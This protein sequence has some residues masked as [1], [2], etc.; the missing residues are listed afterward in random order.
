MPTGVTS[1]SSGNVYSITGVFNANTWTA[2]KQANVIVPDREANFSFTANLQYPS[3]ANTSV[4][5]TWSWTNSVTI[6]NTNPDV[7][8][9]TTYNFAEDNATRILYSINDPD[10][11]IVNYTVRVAPRAGTT[12]TILLNGVNQGIGNAATITGNVAT[13]DA[14]NI[15]YVPY[16]DDTSTVNLRADAYKTNGVG[17]V[18]IE[19]NVSLTL[20][21]TSTHSDYSLPQTYNENTFTAPIL[22]TDLDPLATD[23]TITARQTSGNI[24]SWFV[25][26]AVHSSANIVY[27]LNTTKANINAAN[28]V[29]F[30]AIGD[31]GNVV[32]TYS[33][34]KN[35][36][37]FGNIVQASNVTQTLSVG[38]TYPDVVNIIDRSYTA[39]T[40]NQIFANSTPAIDDGPDY[41]QTYTISLNSSLGEFSADSINFANTL[42]LSGN[43]TTINNVFA[44]I[45]FATRPG[46]YLGNGTYTYTQA[47]SG[48]LQTSLTRSLTGTNAN[49]V[50]SNL[51]FGTGSTSWTPSARDIRYLRAE[52]VVI[53]GGGAGRYGG[54]GGGGAGK[55]NVFDLSNTTYTFSVGAG[56]QAVPTIFSRGETSTGFGITSTG[57]TA[58]T[59]GGYSQRGGSS[60]SSTGGVA[61]HSAQLGGTGGVNAVGM[62]GSGGGAGGPGSNLTSIDP[63]YGGAGYEGGG[64]GGGGVQ[65]YNGAYNPGSF[66]GTPGGGGGAQIP[67]SPEPIIVPGA[68]G[69]V[70]IRFTPK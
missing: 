47:R 69:A 50:Y 43:L 6:A 33:Q 66:G 14:A 3:T 44:N 36:S 58:V 57:G 8:F 5:N 46:Q 1:S 4:T 49:L 64:L 12:G 21:C 68:D 45:A 7:L 55:T 40:I 16:P 20:T 56:G 11:T 23:Y 61:P 29:F 22:V 13:V 25:N 15:T 28:L 59:S 63:A 35:N 39:N 31:N 54:G 27:S 38:T 52:A 10:P 48:I 26:G 9:T 30:P 18:S 62:G 42:S 34:S 37:L 32:L 51:T 67:A 65:Y 70:I 24:G 60:G 53:G 2:V 17:N 41:G 19:S